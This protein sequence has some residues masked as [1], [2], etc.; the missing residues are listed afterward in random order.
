MADDNTRRN[1]ALT[2][3]FASAVSATIIQ[4]G[5][6]LIWGGSLVT[7]TDLL[8]KRQQEILTNM[9]QIEMRGSRNIPLIEQQQK[10]LRE[11]QDKIVQSLDMVYNL[12]NDHMRNQTDIQRLALIEERLKITNDRLAS[13]ERVMSAL[14]Q[15]IPRAPPIPQP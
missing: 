7:R 6:L 12:V 5:G 2:A 13:V 1:T 14:T 9:Y 4:V 10:D 3:I 15:I 8:E 11:R